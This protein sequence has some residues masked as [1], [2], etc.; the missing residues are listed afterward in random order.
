MIVMRWTFQI[1]PGKFDEALKLAKE[2]RDNIWNFYT[3]RIYTSNIG[4]W[5]TIVIENEFKDMAERAKNVEQVAA[6]EEWGPWI[7]GWTEV[8]TG[9]GKNEVWNIE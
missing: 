9:T 8:I 6:K 2:G 5:N 1:K 3:S 7:A 4:P